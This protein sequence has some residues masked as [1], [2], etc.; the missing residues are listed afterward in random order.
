MSTIDKKDG[1]VLLFSGIL[2]Q[3]FGEPEWFQ[4]EDDYTAIFIKI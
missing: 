1:Q 2:V 3:F 4:Y